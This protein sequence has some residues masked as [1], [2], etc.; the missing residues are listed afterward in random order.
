MNLPSLMLSPAKPKDATCK[1]LPLKAWLPFKQNHRFTYANVHRR[2]AYNTV[3]QSQHTRGISLDE[4]V[5]GHTCRR[6]PDGRTTYFLAY[7]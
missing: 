7:E 1:T 6:R 2:F 4:E 5:Q 3:H